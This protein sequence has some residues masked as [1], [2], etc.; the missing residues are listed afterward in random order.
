MPPEQQEFKVG[1]L[2][3]GFR[4]MAELGRGARSIVYLV[5]DPETKQI[6]ALKH[7][8]KVGPKDD[9]FLEQA[10]MECRISGDLEHPAIRKIHKIIKKKSGLLTVKELYLVMELVDGVSIDVQPPKTFEQAVHIFYQTASAMAHM[11][12]RGYAH[13]DMKPNNVVVDD[14]GS[15]KIIDLG[16]ACKI[17]T[18]KP[19]IQGTPDYIAPEQ[20]HLKPI[21]AKTDIYNL[22]AMMYWVLTR[23]Y[24]PTALPKGDSLVSSVDPHLMSRPTPAIEINKKIPPKLND[25]IMQCVEIDSDAR[26]ADMQTVSNKL[27][28]I[29]GIL[30]ARQGLSDSKVNVDPPTDA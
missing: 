24:I 6:W 30:L 20:V 5:Q 25:L 17:G 22:G 13:A 27:N 9:R 18:V 8:E 14:K 12:D 11:H 2:V 23:K 3:E 7:V 16:Q 19:R 29:H 26:P 15:V 21:T 1:Q 10:E 4:V 28:L